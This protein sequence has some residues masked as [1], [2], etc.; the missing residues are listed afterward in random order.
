MSRKI[1]TEDEIENEIERLRQSDCVALARKEQRICLC[2]V[3]I[4][5]TAFVSSLSSS[6]PFSSFSMRP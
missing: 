2:S 6:C 1:F 5:V 3:A 4:V